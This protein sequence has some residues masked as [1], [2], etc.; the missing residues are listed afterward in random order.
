MKPLADIELHSIVI[1]QVGNGIQFH[2]GQE[3]RVS[4]GKIAKITHIVRDENS[5]EEFKEVPYIVYGEVDGVI[6]VIKF[7]IN[8]PIYASC[9]TE[10]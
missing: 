3:V 5:Y 6:K 2:V 9:I 1:G 10:L 7:C 8:Q 4:D